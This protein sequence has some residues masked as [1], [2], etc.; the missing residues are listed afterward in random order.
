MIIKHLVSVR[1]VCVRVIIARSSLSEYIQPLQSAPK[2]AADV[3]SRTSCGRHRLH[4]GQVSDLQALRSLKGR[5]CGPG[6]KAPTT[7]SWRRRSTVHAR[8]QAAYAAIVD[9]ASCAT[10]S[11]C[12]MA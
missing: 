3:R 2:D 5:C 9:A 12:S 4:Q 7:T 6:Y 8:T 1:S 10:G 11:L